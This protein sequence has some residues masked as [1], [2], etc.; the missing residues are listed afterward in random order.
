MF[1]SK[2]RIWKVNG[3]PL[4]NPRKHHYCPVMYLE[5]FTNSAGRFW[6]SDFSKKQPRS[7]IPKNEAHQ[8]DYN[9]LDVDSGSDPFHVERNFGGLEGE[10]KTVITQVI[11]SKKIPDGEQ[12]AW[13]M[14]F[15]GFSAARVPH[16]R[17]TLNNFFDDIKKKAFKIFLAKDKRSRETFPQVLKEQ[18]Y[19]LDSFEGINHFVENKVSKDSKNQA[20]QGMIDMGAKITNI[21]AE[22]NWAVVINESGHDFV[23]CDNPVDLQW[24]NE[25]RARSVGFGLLGTVVEMPLSANVALAGT[26]EELPEKIVIDDRRAIAAFNANASR[27]RLRN[28]FSASEYFV[29]MDEEGEVQSSE[30]MFVAH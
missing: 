3:K 8:R 1:R 25:P 24:E 23:T 15:I 7:T 17:G 22:R 5:N 18:G 30:S 6:A 19:N 2:S 29:V 16:V 10:W 14:S 11:E 20:V 12:F 4:N 26:F 27:R 13:L 21:L 9:R 28:V